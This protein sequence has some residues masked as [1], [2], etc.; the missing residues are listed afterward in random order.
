MP[1]HR[2]KENGAPKVAGFRR[3][4]I[5]MAVPTNATPGEIFFGRANEVAP[6]AEIGV[7]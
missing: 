2:P 5:E 7:C 3:G 4:F 6:V 1:I